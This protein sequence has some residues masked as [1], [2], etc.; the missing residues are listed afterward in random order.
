MKTNFSI[1]P[2]IK[3]ALKD[4]SD[5]TKI[6]HIFKQANIHRYLYIIKYNGEIIKIGIQWKVIDWADRI[7]T[8]I[9]HMPGWNKPLL[10]RSD[11]KTG[12]A[13][14][15]LIEK[16]DSISYH[17]DNIEVEIF[18]FTS[19]PFQ[20]NSTIYAEMQNAEEELKTE[21]YKTYNRYP[22]GNLKQEPIRSIIKTETFFDLFSKVN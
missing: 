2:R 21:F 16:V 19:Y 18:D 15:S 4:L 3:I 17:K 14:R 11:K 8:Q 13:T 10:K 22:V 20:R 1:T 7:Y 9:G 5:Y 12:T 6:K